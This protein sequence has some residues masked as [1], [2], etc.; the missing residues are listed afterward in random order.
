MEPNLIMQTAAVLLALAAIGGA[1]MAIIR[2]GG[3][4]HP[5]TWLAMLHGF[6]AAAAVTLLLYACF[7]VGLP[8]LAKAALALF[9]IAALGGAVLNLNYHWKQLPLPKS[10]ML[11][12]GALAVVGFLLLLGAIFGSHA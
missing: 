1:T 6:L 8:T 9:V 3:K 10:L 2:F 11:A 7:T 12:H 5:P 4:P